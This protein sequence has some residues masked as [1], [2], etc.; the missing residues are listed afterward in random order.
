MKHNGNL[1]SAIYTREL[2]GRSAE[3]STKSFMT[4]GRAVVYSAV[5]RSLNFSPPCSQ[6]AGAPVVQ[7]VQSGLTEL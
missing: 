5:Q 3:V 1:M 4:G 6:F 2:Y 7:S